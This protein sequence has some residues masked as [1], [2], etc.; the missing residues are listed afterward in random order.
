VTTE[1]FPGM[2]SKFFLKTFVTIPVAP[3]IAGILLRFRLHIHCIFVRKLLYFSFVSAS[4]CTK[5]LS[6][7]TATSINIR[8]FLYVFNYY[9]WPICC[10]FSVCVYCM[11]HNTVTSPCSYIGLCMYVYHVFVISMPRALH[12]E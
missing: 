12:I 3:V 8:V 11:I 1:C 5:F 2:A 6:A 4:F 9:I 7:D 10:N